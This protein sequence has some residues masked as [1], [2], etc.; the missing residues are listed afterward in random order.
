MIK[1]RLVNRQVALLVAVGLFLLIG[2]LYLRKGV[3][4][5]IVNNT[6][7]VLKNI[8]ITYTGGALCVKELDSHTSYG[9]RINPSGEANL[10]IEWFNL[11]GVK[12]SHIIDVYFEHN[13]RGSVEI[14]VGPNNRVSWTNK[15]KLP[16]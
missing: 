14:V 13:Y 6:Q 15:I 11:S 10:K 5:C 16:W 7:T 4:V 1:R 2:Y 3:Y 8:N 9:K 12:Q